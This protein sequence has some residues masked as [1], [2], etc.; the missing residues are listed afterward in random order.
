MDW[1]GT[2]HVSDLVMA[3]AYTGADL[4]GKG[5]EFVYLEDPDFRRFWPDS[6]QFTG[7]LHWLVGRGRSGIC[8]VRML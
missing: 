7:S 6:E 2:E 1:Y 8:L 5:S 4:V 3:V